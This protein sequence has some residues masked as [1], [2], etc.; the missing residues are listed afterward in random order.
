MNKIKFLIILFIACST[1]TAAQN[2][3]FAGVN[4]AFYAPTG[5][6]DVRFKPAM[7]GQFYIGKQT[8]EKW[9]W[10][11]QFEY[12]KFTKQNQ[13]KLEIKQKSRAD[14]NI[15]T[16]P[17]P[18]A[19]MDLQVAGASAQ[20][21]VTLY[22]NDFMKAGINF[23]F[24]IYRWEFSRKAFSGSLVADVNGTP[25]VIDSVNLTPVK[26]LDWSGG[27]NAGASASI[28]LFDPLYFNVSANY[29][30]IMGELWSALAIS[31]ENV[32]VFQMYELKAGLSIEF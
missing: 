10:A 23:G 14:N 7:G 18:D 12:F 25:T 6:L 5:S 15:Y 19:I 30:A 8:S 9:Q 32:S 24:G 13:D 21:N 27:F 2:N 28:K 31:L 16:F 26:Q 1:F 22:K 3:F 4:G 17:F 11:G 29:K 20:A